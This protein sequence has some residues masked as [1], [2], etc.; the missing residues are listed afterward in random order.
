[1]LLRKPLEVTQWIKVAAYA[2][3]FLASYYAR[4]GLICANVDGHHAS[5]EKITRYQMSHRKLRSIV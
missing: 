2:I 4:C 1:L 5:E 3:I